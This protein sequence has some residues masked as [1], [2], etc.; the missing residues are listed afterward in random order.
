MVAG[1]DE[2]GRGPLAGPLVVAAVILPQRWRPR[3]PIDDSKRLTPAQREAAYG[4]VRRHALGW[5]VVVISP[6][7][8][9]RVN[10]LKATLQGMA[11]AL[12]RIKPAPDFALVDGNRLPELQVPARALVQ[13]DARS[14]TIAAA[15]I[16]AKVVRD[17]LMAV[18]G[19]RFPQWGFERHKGYPT[20]E[21]RYALAAHGPSPIHR[22]SFCA[23]ALS[24]S[25][26][27]RIESRWP[28]ENRLERGAN[29]PPLNISS[30]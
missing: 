7:E 16:L 12:A 17:R 6:Q 2:A 5:R 19:A 26:R 25:E 23:K 11:L 20:L 28:T 10:I 13:G 21:H 22:R 15:S 27:K 18:Y 9:D 8:V 24:E 4:A 14:R 3:V 1:V 30:G 29:R